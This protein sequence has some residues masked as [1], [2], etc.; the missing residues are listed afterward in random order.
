MLDTLIYKLLAEQPQYSDVS[1]PADTDSKRRLFRS[2]VNVRPPLPVDAKFLQLQD[3]YLQR[4][5]ADKGIVD[6]ADL[7]EVQPRIYLWQG[8]ITRL[9]VDAI[10]NAA[11][12]T[13]L[14]CYVPC[15]GCIDNA[16]H[17][18]AGVQLRRKCNELMEQQGQTEPTG[19]AKITPA[20][21]LP[22]SYIL[23]TVGP[24]IR[25]K[26]TKAQCAELASCYRS[27]FELADKQNLKSI[28]YCC[29]ST[30]EFRFPNQQAAEI[31]IHTVFECLQST[32]SISK[33][34]FNVFKKEDYNIYANLLRKNQ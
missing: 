14:G 18:F 1:I 6:I 9:K 13:M 31:A 29:I 21:N 2:L 19:S 8:D 17:T 30:G 15:H 26:P 7:E 5:L 34:I 16:I 10:V 33:V 11:N 23:H 32:K 3:S 4:E 12:N 20:Y 24:I 28:A 25:N 27:C 22:S